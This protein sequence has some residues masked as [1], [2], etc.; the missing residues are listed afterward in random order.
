MRT[1]QPGV[2]R[3]FKGKLYNVLCIATHSE[4]MEHMVVYQAMYGDMRVYVRPY[5]MFVSEV[6]K[7]KYPD[8][9]QKYRFQKE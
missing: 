2:Y 1:I 3:H 4:T 7:N 8:V 9:K 6:D 5:N